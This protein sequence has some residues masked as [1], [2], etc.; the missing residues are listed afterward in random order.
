ME[1]EQK[2]GTEKSQEDSGL[3]INCRVK[4]TPKGFS[5]WIPKGAFKEGGEE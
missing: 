1:N 5:I 2:S 4:E 3:W